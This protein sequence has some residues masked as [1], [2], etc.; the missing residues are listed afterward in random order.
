MAET[1]RCELV[2]TWERVRK[3][4]RNIGNRAQK[5]WIFD[6]R[7]KSRAQ[8]RVAKISQFKFRM[9]RAEVSNSGDEYQDR[10]REKGRFDEKSYQKSPRAYSSY[11]IV[12][13]SPTKPT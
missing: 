4:S 2:L 8:S 3:R 5:Y 9:G 12:I 6:L 10:E 11:Y 1:Q 13:L 7:H